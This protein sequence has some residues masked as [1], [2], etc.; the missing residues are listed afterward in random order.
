MQRQRRTRQG[1]LFEQDRPARPVTGAQREHL[2][3][4]LG[5]LMLEVMTHPDALRTG[6]DHE[7]DHG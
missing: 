2:I 1:V 6:D 7:S 3:R 4:L 5:A